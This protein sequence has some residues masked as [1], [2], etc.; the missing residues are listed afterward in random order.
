[1]FLKHYDVTKWYNNK[2]NYKFLGF[3]NYQKNYK[4]NNKKTRTSWVGVGLTNVLGENV[5]KVI[6]KGEFY[7]YLYAK[8]KSLLTN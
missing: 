1:M 5:R 8:N 7:P 4:V 2:R 3:S 6:Y